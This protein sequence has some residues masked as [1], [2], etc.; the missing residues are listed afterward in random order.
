MV[1][2]LSRDG[3][4]GFH[5]VDVR[6]NLTT[7]QQNKVPLLPL[8]TSPEGGE[9][10]ISIG[11]LAGAGGTLG[12]TSAQIAEAKA[13]GVKPAGGAGFAY[14]QGPDAAIVEYLGNMPAERLNHVHMYQADPL[15]AVLWYARPN[16]SGPLPT[17]SGC[18]GERSE[19]SWPAL[20]MMSPCSGTQGRAT[21]P[22]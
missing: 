1:A 16:G 11:H 13:N 15:C 6:N 3:L 9:V 19:R 2:A 18:K 10:L 21:L 7:Y 12:R 22:S 17:E 8:Y 4:F 20:L 14:M 5:V